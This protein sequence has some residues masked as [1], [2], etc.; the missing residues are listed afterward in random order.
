MLRIPEMLFHKAS[1]LGFNCSTTQKEHF[2]VPACAEENWSLIY[3]SG[4]WVLLIDGV[5]QM[6]LRYEEVIHFLT[7]RAQ[8]AQQVGDL[9]TA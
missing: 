3:R 1:E 8:S 4:Q 6:N 7:R 9:Q 5:P 2:I